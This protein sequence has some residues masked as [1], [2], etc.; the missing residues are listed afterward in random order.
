MSSAS[1]Q[2]ESV[3]PTVKVRIG[4]QFEKYIGLPFWPE[5]NEVINISKDVHPKLGE[6]KK[7]QALLASLEKR[8]FTKKEYE[9]MVKRSQ[10]PFYTIDDSDD[11]EGEIII[12]ERVLQSLHKQ[13]IARSSKGCSAHREQRVDVHRR[14]RC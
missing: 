9:R 11:G 2:V 3:A 14:S 1:T 7:E 6:A 4:L 13:R 5:T 10:R 12:P 8:G